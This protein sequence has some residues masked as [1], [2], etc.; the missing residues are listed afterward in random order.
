MH[1]DN[2]RPERA[3]N[4]YCLPLPLF[5]EFSWAAQLSS[6][7]I[8]SNSLRVSN[9]QAD[10]IFWKQ[11]LPFP[12]VWPISLGAAGLHLKKGW[13]RRQNKGISSRRRRVN[14]WTPTS[15]AWG[16]PAV[17]HDSSK[18]HS[19]GFCSTGCKMQPLRMIQD[20]TLRC[21]ASQHSS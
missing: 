7:S 19:W 21:Q 16:T 3:S 6:T 17:S 10:D 5:M 12:V 11:T 13:E 14:H 20:M 2:F 15:Q 4:N 8:T 1:K 18:C 9:L